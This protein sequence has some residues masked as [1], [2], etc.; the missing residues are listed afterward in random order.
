MYAALAV[1]AVSF[2]S[3]DDDNNTPDDPDAMRLG[4]GLFVVNE[5]NYGY[6]NSSITYYNPA[7]GKVTD[8]VF[9]SA[10]DMKLGD[11]AQS[12]TIHGGDAWILVNNSHVVFVVN[13]TTMVEKGR[14]EDVGSP[15]YIH[16]VSPD[17]AYLTQL[18]DNRIFIINPKTYSITGY[19][20]V[21]GMEKATGSTEQM[22]QQGKYVYVNCWS[23]QNSII[24]I[25]TDTD[26]VV[27]GVEVGIQP[28]SITLDAD[29]NLWAL[30]DGGYEGNPVGYEAPALWMVNTSDF[31]ATKKIEMP[32]FTYPSE[33]QA[34]ASG[35]Y[36][37]WLNGGVW[38]MG[39]HDTAMPAQAYISR[40]GSHFYGL[41]I[42]PSNGDIYA[43]DAIDYTQRGI[44]YRYS[45]AGDELG[46]FYAGIIPGSFCWKK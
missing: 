31:T 17:K 15:R 6:S 33:L 16:F 37:Y 39:I 3:C 32:M 26:R 4:A 14:I 1:A 35:N 24:K 20:E 43:A 19:I 25:D 28:V 42:N 12:M 13:S 34:D 36:L 11:M 10:N 29:G 27:A 22:V 44:V 5:G 7:D 38:R 30:T 23:Y 8:D 18:N 9:T 41:T 45:A 21:P 2:T 40:E 46:S